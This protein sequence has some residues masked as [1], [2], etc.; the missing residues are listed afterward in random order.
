MQ[1]A[2]RNS[3]LGDVV[4]LEDG[5]GPILLVCEHASNRI[6]ACFDRLGLPEAA[7]EAHIAWDPGA[8]GVARS[9]ADAWRAPLVWGGV[10]RLVYD[11]N[12][13]PE[14]ESAMPSLSED[15]VIPGNLDLS[16]TARS[17]R[18]LGIY[19]PFH[20]HV[21]SLIQADPKPR[22]L[23]TIHSFTPVYLGQRREVEIGLLHGQD[24]RFARAMLACRPADLHHDIRLNEPYSAADGVAHTLDKHGP[25]NGLHSIMIEIRNDLIDTPERQSTMAARLAPWITDTLERLTL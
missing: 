16:A 10:S 2:I 8:L 6:P 17:E 1:V 25:A 9:L 13:P 15:T 21:S 11:C 4:H 14:A 18:A 20:A 19:E 23:A 22:L 12:R 5:T 24:D 3:D 7:L